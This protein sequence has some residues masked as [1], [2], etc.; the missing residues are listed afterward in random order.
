MKHHGT[1]PSPGN[2]FTKSLPSSIMTDATTPRP[3]PVILPEFPSMSDSLPPEVLP[4]AM[5]ENAN[6]RT[7]SESTTN[8]IGLMD[9]SNTQSSEGSLSDSN[10][11]MNDLLGDDRLLGQEEDFSNSLKKM[12]IMANDCGDDDRTPKHHSRSFDDPITVVDRP[13]SS[14]T[15]KL[16]MPNGNTRIILPAPMQDATSNK[17]ELNVGSHDDTSSRNFSNS[18]I[19]GGSN[20]KQPPQQHNINTNAQIPR[21]PP[22]VSSQLQASATSDPVMLNQGDMIDFDGDLG[23]FGAFYEANNNQNNKSSSRQHRHRHAR[24]TINNHGEVVERSP[25][26]SPTPQD[27]ADTRLHISFSDDE[28]TENSED[29]GV[30]RPPRALESMNFDEIDSLSS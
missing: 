21:I 2:P 15:G 26:E 4:S 23:D 18:E 24:L 22:P 27:I 8:N 13:P 12:N 1:T 7:S 9:M 16:T 28:N 3:A 20:N 6:T 5:F 30:P 19:G 14:N 25:S 10:N 29:S 11:E 17:L